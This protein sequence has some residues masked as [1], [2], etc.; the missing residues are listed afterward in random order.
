MIDFDV[1]ILLKTDFWIY[2]VEALD[3]TWLGVNW[4]RNDSKLSQKIFKTVKK[5]WETSNQTSAVDNQNLN[6]NKRN[7]IKT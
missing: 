6:C 7:F 3:S 1:W 4:E 5:S 2:S